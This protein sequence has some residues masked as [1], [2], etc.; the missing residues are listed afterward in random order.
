MTFYNNNHGMKII[1]YSNFIKIEIYK[2]AELYIPFIN[3]RNIGASL[4]EEKN[5]VYS[6][7]KT[8]LNA[9]IFIA[10]NVPK[11]RFP[12]DIKDTHIVNTD[13]LLTVAYTLPAFIVKDILNYIRMLK[14]GTIKN[15]SNIFMGEEPKNLFSSVIAEYIDLRD[16][17]KKGDKLNVEGSVDSVV[18]N[19]YKFV[20]GDVNLL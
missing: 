17:L 16:T 8:R 11:I 6:A 13:E 4:D 12:E 7:P 14:N 18:W 15:A 9:L 20:L 5:N 10:Q 3:L 2:N 19:G 1:V